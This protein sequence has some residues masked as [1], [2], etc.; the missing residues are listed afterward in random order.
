MRSSCYPELTYFSQLWSHFEAFC[1]RKKGPV[2]GDSKICYPFKRNRNFET[3]FI[4]MRDS[5]VKV[6]Y[7]CYTW[8]YV[9]CMIIQ[10]L[11]DRTYSFYF[12]SKL[13][14]SDKI[15]AFLNAKRFKLWFA[16]T[17]NKHKSSSELDNILLLTDSHC[18]VT[19]PDLKMNGQPISAPCLVT[20]CSTWHSDYSQVTDR[21][22]QWVP[23]AESW[24]CLRI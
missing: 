19:E 14:S 23:L 1:L 18:V 15:F 21:R 10:L 2:M 3:G 9:L 17:K 22:E 20:A 13:T 7:V 16:V 12:P 11:A 5:E 4:V 24:Q 6:A 8:C